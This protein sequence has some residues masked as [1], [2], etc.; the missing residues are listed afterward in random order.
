MHKLLACGQH[1][2]FNLADRV[3]SFRS[4]Q[5]FSERTVSFAN[6][7]QKWR[8]L[9]KQLMVA[10]KQNG[11]GLKHLEA[12]TLKYGEEMLQ[13]MED[14]GGEPFDPAEL[15]IT[16]IASMM[17]TLMY[18]CTTEEEVKKHIDHEKQLVHVLQPNGAFL[19]LDILPISRLFVPSV[20]NAY[21][22]FTA[23]INSYATLYENITASRRRI[24]KHPQVE[25]FIDHFLKLSITNEFDEDKSRIVDELDIAAVG[26]DMFGAGM[27]TTFSTLQMMLAALVNHQEIQ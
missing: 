11:D 3:Q 1:F 7:T 10:M 2:C 14:Y 8:Y 5:L 13:K 4:G 21:A 20:K 25:Y 6:D 27:M 12:M 23:V 26:S 18:G 15:L 9:K 17:L 19:M 22:K 24:Y 16:T